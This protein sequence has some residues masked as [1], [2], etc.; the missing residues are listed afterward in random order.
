MALVA[1]QNR[2][3]APALFAF[4]SPCTEDDQNIFQ[5]TCSETKFDYYHG[6]L[7]K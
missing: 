1:I 2:S 7:G 4:P 5:V 3:A 6:L